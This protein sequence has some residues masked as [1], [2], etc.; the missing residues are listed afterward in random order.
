[1]NVLAIEPFYGGSHRAFLDGWAKHSRHDFT[2]LE[3]PAHKWKWRMR[4]APVTLAQRLTE[5]EFRDREFDCLWCSDM[6]NLAEFLG[7]APPAIQALPCVT[8][9]HENQLTYPVR[10]AEERDLHFAYTNFTTCAAADQVWFN[11][12]FH[13]TDYLKALRTC[14]QRMPDYRTLDLVDEIE[15]KSSVQYPGIETDA[16]A[17]TSHDGPLRI[18]WNARWEHDKNPE[19]FFAALRFLKNHD[20]PFEL[21]VLGESFRDSP[22]IFEIAR[23]EFR[24]QTLQWGFAES[25]QAYGDWLS[26]MDVVVS[27]AIH[28]FFGI[29]IVEAVAAGAVPLLPRRL[30]YPEVIAKLQDERSDWPLDILYDGTVQDLGTKLMETARNK[31]HLPSVARSLSGQA[32]RFAWSTRAKELD[33][34]LESVK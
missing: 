21:I 13:R 7:L 33:V 19:D 30:A 15:T 26:Q 6:L 11:S 9:F 31:E 29:G 14:L 23:D 17:R 1:M 10:K 12:E 25:Q 22:A 20:V 4:H 28:E 32:D 34:A 16:T 24:A 2:I 5:P 27:T 18:G 8:Y 3:L